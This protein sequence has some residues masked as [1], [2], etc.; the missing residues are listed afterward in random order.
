MKMQ[1]MWKEA[2]TEKQHSEDAAPLKSIGDIKF[3]EN[4]PMFPFVMW[5]QKW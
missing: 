2:S 5:I 1:F 4:N 3:V